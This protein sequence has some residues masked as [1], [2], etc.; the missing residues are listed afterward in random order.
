MAVEKWGRRTGWGEQRRGG[1]D[2]SEV[3]L[4]RGT[5]R[6]PVNIDSDINNQRQDC[7]VGMVCVGCTSR[8]GKERREYNGWSSYT[9]MKQNKETSY[10]CFK[11]GRVGVI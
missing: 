11:W 6:N 10:N 2:Q 4:Q 3:H 9:Y 5:S 1:A 8:A 7:E